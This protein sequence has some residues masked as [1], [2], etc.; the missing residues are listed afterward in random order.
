MAP[1]WLSHLFL[2]VREAHESFRDLQLYME[3]MVSE[4]QQINFN[5]TPRHDLFN[6]LLIG[7]EDSWDNISDKFTDQ[8]LFANMFL[9][10]LAG[11]ETTAHSLAYTLGLLAIHEDEQEKLYRHIIDNLGGV[12]IPSYEQMGRFSYVL[13]T[14][15]EALR[16][17]PI[18]PALSKQ[19]AEDTTIPKR[20]SDG[21]IEHIPVP[22]DSH[23]LLNII[24][25]HYH[26]KY[27]SDPEKF[28]PSRFLGEWN[29]DAYVPFSGG[30][31]ACIGR[32][33]AEV[34]KAF[35]SQAVA[36]LVVLLKHYKIEMKD[37]EEYTGLDVLQKRARLLRSRTHLN[38][39]PTHEPLVFRKRE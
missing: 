12:E 39:G 10:L 34:E 23:I 6:A 24:A 4:R 5:E 36:L 33:F 37:P 7:N 28:D 1:E 17:F 30:M 19:A 31:R 20:K 3:G 8:Q 14:F 26:P 2:M 18:V 35:I 15:Y 27:W 29:R 22:K 16:L 32:R 38:L 21:G 11:H 13:A 25:L 9:F